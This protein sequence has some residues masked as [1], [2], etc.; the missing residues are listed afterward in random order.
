MDEE[1][2]ER[3]RKRIQP[4]YRKGGGHGF[5]HTERVYELALKISEGED[6]D[7]DVVR[8]ATLLHDIA[9]EKQ[10][11]SDTNICHAERGAKIAEEILEEV[12]FPSDKVDNVVHCIGVHRYSK[13]LAT[14][15]KEAEILRDADRLEVLGAVGIARAFE[16]GGVRGRVSYDP[17]DSHTTIGQLK[18]KSLK[19][20]PETFKTLG[21][22]KIAKERY[23]F[24]EQFVN[25]F[26]KEW[27]GEL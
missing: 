24:V 7:L 15:T 21:A 26:E 2:F 5:D 13:G 6:V 8:V 19:I 27:R 3:L 10:D 11:E 4:Y 23:K 9:R 12:D 17:E 16:R 14:E 1:F 18:I 20:F 25:R 22:Q